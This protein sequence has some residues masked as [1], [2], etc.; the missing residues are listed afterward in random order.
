MSMA[1]ST[2]S[3]A[4]PLRVPLMLAALLLLPL[5]AFGAEPLPV[6]NVDPKAIS[7]SGLSSGGF[8]AVQFQVAFSRLVMGA[9]ILSGGPYDCAEDDPQRAESVC[10]CTKP[11]CSDISA[12]A[13]ARLADITDKRAAEQLIDPIRYLAR[14]RV[15]VYSG[16]ADTIVPAATTETLLAYYGRFIEAKKIRHKQLAGAQHALPIDAPG[17]PCS[18]LGDPFINNCHF[19]AAHALLAWIYGPLRRRNHSTPSGSTIEFD[20][21]EFI[22]TPTKQGMAETGWLYVPRACARGKKC[23]LHIAF[24]GCRQYQDYS[25]GG[26]RFGTTFVDQAGYKETADTNNIVV[27]FPQATASAA[28]PN[29]CWDFW[30]YTN[31]DYATR[32]GIQMVAVKRMVDRIANRP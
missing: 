16:G 11:P 15:W 30:G 28:N 31:A 13:S 1:T 24:H 3:R 8:M 17:N 9:G 2:K 20:Q 7:V 19:D 18:Y 10:A 5:Q 26:H 4:M 14:Q 22:A 25:Y 21:G 27:L 6:L 12:A 23:R 32:A 29:G